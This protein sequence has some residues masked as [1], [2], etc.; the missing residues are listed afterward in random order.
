MSPNL[1]EFIY[2][3]ANGTIPS[4]RGRQ[5]QAE[6]KGKRLLKRK[7]SKYERLVLMTL[8]RW[9][10]VGRHEVPLIMNN[11]YNIQPGHRQEFLTIPCE[12]QINDI[13]IKDTHNVLSEV[14]KDVDFHR[15]SP[16][17]KEILAH[18]ESSAYTAGIAIHKRTP[19]D[20]SE[21]RK[22]R[23][24]ERHVPSHHIRATFEPP[25]SSFSSR[26]LQE[27]RQQHSQIQRQMS[28][29]SDRTDFLSVKEEETEYIEISDD[30]EPATPSQLNSSPPENY[31]SSSTSV[32]M[33]G[34]SS[35]SA[36]TKDL[37]ITSII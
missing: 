22:R 28:V 18:I 33:P 36:C 15:K 20:D 19:E 1:Q 24:T 29:S 5:L 12:A 31:P 37:F 21:R 14:Y 30:D 25:S 27:I 8:N 17:I 23:L 35:P 9:Y 3:S 13:R 34:K 2:H 6:L 32:T 7:W 26:R 16:A 10:D 4:L 11:F